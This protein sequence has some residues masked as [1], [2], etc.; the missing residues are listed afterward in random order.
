MQARVDHVRDGLRKLRVSGPL[1]CAREPRAHKA[2][3]K[4]VPKDPCTQTVYAL[5]SKLSLYRYF[6]AKVYTMWVHGPLR[7][8]FGVIQGLW[9]R[10]EGLRPE[11]TTDCVTLPTRAKESAK[12]QGDFGETGARPC[13]RS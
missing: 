6:L 4:N 2:G 10:V 5:A 11:G 9:L 3:R 1:A 7:M 13:V 8:Y 12:G